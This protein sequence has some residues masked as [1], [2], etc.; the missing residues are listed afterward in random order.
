MRD[1]VYFRTGLFDAAGAP[2]SPH[3]PGRDV[4][5]WLAERLSALS[6]VC[7]EPFP[8]DGWML[9]V[10][11]GLQKFDIHIQLVGEPSETP[12]WTAAIGSPALPWRFLL[13]KKILRDQLNS[14]LESS[15]EIS[16]VVWSGS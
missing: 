10:T 16:N 12:R 8:K 3:R 1:H 9:S 15:A 4:A 11:V 14:V 6:I 7:G 5:D 2:G 13:E